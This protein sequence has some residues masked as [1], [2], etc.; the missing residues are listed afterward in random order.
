MQLSIRARFAL[1]GAAVV[2]SACG[3]VLIRSHPS[4]DP[5]P[6][7]EDREITKRLGEVAAL[8]AIPLLDHIVLGHAGF[9]S[10][11]DSETDLRRT[12]R[13]PDG[14]SPTT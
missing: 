8:V 6:S 10:F 1:F 5:T 12:W 4:G 9:Y 13:A 14:S 7:A 3:V 2:A 11:A